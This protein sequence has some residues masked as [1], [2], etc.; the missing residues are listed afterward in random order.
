MM[1][2]QLHT[3]NLSDDTRKTI[4]KTTTTTKYFTNGLYWANVSQKAE[5]HTDLKSTL[6]KLILILIAGP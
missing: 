2:T 5:G 4:K 6:G 3:R 1:E